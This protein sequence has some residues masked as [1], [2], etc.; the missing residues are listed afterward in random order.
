MQSKVKRIT[1]NQAGVPPIDQAKIVHLERV[2]GIVSNLSTRTN[3][4]NFR[5]RRRN[6]HHYDDS[7]NRYT[8]PQC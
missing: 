6:Y 8:I 1:I 4:D 3:Y 2:K 7:D 5:K